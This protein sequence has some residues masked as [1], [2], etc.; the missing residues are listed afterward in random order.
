MLV[1]HLNRR[2]KTFIFFSA[3]SLGSFPSFYLFQPSLVHH[4]V[5]IVGCCFFTCPG[6]RNSQ[7]SSDLPSILVYCPTPNR[8]KIPA[9]SRGRTVEWRSPLE[10]L[11]TG[12]SANSPS[13]I[14][15]LLLAKNWANAP[16][17]CLF[18]GCPFA[19]ILV[20]TLSWTMLR[21]SD[22]ARE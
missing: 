20:Y 7:S 18:S 6:R 14:L 8:C 13:G 1:I 19:V 22:R 2:W 12:P 11:D 3:M 10:L 4:D 5:S 9:V 16:R 17:E 21:H 15:K